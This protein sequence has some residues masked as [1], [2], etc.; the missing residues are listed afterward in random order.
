[1][2]AHGRTLT[3][4]AAQ[5]DRTDKILLSLCSGSCCLVTEAHVSYK[6]KISERKDNWMAAIPLVDVQTH[7]V[8]WGYPS[9]GQ[10]A[11]ESILDSSDLANRKKCYSKVKNAESTQHSISNNFYR[12]LVLFFVHHLL[13]RRP[14]DI[15]WPLFDKCWS[16]KTIIFL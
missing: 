15:P 12:Y 4:A 3:G 16:A 6:K 2:R 5:R 7:C 8:Q 11:E 9:W 14:V 13:S 1:M 10:K